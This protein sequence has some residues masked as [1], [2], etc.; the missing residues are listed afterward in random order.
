MNTVLKNISPVIQTMLFFLLLVIT[1]LCQCNLPKDRGTQTF[2]KELKT[3]KVLLLYASRDTYASSMFKQTKIAFSYGKIP[4]DEFDISNGELPNLLNYSSIAIA[5]EYIS[6]FTKVTCKEIAD[7]VAAGGGLAVMYRGYNENLSSVFGILSDKAEPDF[8]GKKQSL[9]FTRNLLPGIENCKISEDGISSYIVR[10]DSLATVF[11]KTKSEPIAWLHKYGKGRV[12]YWNTALLSDKVNRG[13]IIK[14]LAMVQPYT[15]TQI[16]NLGLFYLDDFPNSSI[17][18][19]VKP[20]QSEFDQTVTEF[21]YLRWYPDM[22]KLAHKFGIKYTSALIFNYNGRTCPPY[23]FYEWL[24]G[25]LELSEKQAFASQWAVQH[26]APILE[27]GLHGY[28]HQSLTHKNWGSTDNMEKALDRGR[29]RWA[30]DNIGALPYT[31]VPPL[32]IYDSTGTVAL[33]KSYPGIRVIAGLYLGFFDQGQDRE[34]KPEPW[35]KHFYDMPRVTSGFIL[36]DFDKRAM[37]SLLQSPGIWSHFVHPDDVY[38][39]GERYDD[40]LL[41][42]F[43]IKTIHWYGKPQDNGLYFQLKHWLEFARK[44]YPWLR[45][46]KTKNALPELIKFNNT[47]LTHQA[48]GKRIIFKTNETPTFF[49]FYTR[50]GQRVRSI[51]GAKIVWKENDEFTNSYLI[52]AKKKQVSITLSGPIHFAGSAK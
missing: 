45:Y 36:T 12:F 11:A 13:F 19:K 9:F 14:T 46:M 5:T 41:N 6:K 44:N 16:A 29:K 27:L 1:A 38:P 3:P 50:D 37:I 40:D 26:L 25:K 2:I 23:Q 42:S 7:F 52:E 31:Y 43:D 17:N 48:F 32:N 10:I 22:I 39:F 28:N 34:Y 20:I 18:D 51:H 4:F 35:N 8:E 30:I 49:F 33:A 47:I 15:I 24:N 21:Y